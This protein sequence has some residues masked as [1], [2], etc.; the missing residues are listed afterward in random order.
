MVCEWT[1]GASSPSQVVILTIEELE[2]ECG[3]LYLNSFSFS[4]FFEFFLRKK[5]KSNINSWDYIYIYDGPTNQSTLIGA[6]CGSRGQRKD[7]IVVSTSSFLFIQF[8]RSNSKLLSSG[9]NLTYSIG[10]NLIETNFWIDFTTTT[11]PTT[12]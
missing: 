10:M 8:V 12:N 1:I 6:F 2:T 7:D 11:T 3:Y 9:F 5:K 4:L